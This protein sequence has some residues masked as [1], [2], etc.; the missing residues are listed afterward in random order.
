MCYI[1]FII[2]WWLE[3]PKSSSYRRTGELQITS[4]SSSQSKDSLFSSRCI[5]K[6]WNQQTFDLCVKKTDSQNIW[7]QLSHLW[8]IY[9]PP[10]ETFFYSNLNQ[11]GTSHAHSSGRIWLQRVL[12]CAWMRR[13]KLKQSSPYQEIS[14]C[15]ETEQES[16]VQSQ[17]TSTLRIHYTAVEG[18]NWMQSRGNRTW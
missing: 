16:L 13:E 6:G 3:F 8:L 1:I 14:V 10:N 7:Q 9:T 4:L 17:D 5:T 15:Q 11:S 18:L 12:L 2:T